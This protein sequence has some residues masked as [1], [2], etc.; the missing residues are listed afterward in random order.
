[1]LFMVFLCVAD[2]FSY[3]IVFL[4]VFTVQKCLNICNIANMRNFP[5]FLC[6]QT[7]NRFLCRCYLSFMQFV[8]TKVESSKSFIRLNLGFS[9]SSFSNNNFLLFHALLML[10]PI[11]LRP[12]RKIS[13]LSSF[14]FFNFC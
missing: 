13:D 7:G 4:S 3:F 5:L 8:N 9:F 2:H 6:F 12:M 14:F 1:M 10:T 11:I